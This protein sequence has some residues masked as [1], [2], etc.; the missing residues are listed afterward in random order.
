MNTNISE[1]LDRLEQSLDALSASPARTDPDR[2]SAIGDALF[3]I[4][5]AVRDRRREARLR[6]E[7]VDFTRALKAAERN[8]LRSQWRLRQ[9]VNSQ[10]PVDLAPAVE[11]LAIASRRVE[12]ALRDLASDVAGWNRWAKVVNLTAQVASAVAVVLA[13]A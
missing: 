5:E 10:V 8:I 4:Y 1:T 7:A 13:A 9:V 11:R 3:A 2:L 6:H 12:N